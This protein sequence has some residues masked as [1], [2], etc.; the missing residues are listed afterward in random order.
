MD[1][2]HTDHGE[3]L[4]CYKVGASLGAGGIAPYANN[5]L[6]YSKNF[7]T[8]KIITTGPLRTIFE[9]SYKP[10]DFNGA[11]ISEKKRITLDAGSNL[12]KV[13]ITYFCINLDTIPVAIGITKREGKGS[14]MMNEKNG[15]ISYWEPEQKKNGTTGVGIIV[16]NTESMTVVENHLTALASSR[17]SR[18]FQYY[19]GAAWD[20]AG[21]IKN[22]NQWTKYLTEYLLKKQNPVI[23]KFN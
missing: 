11:E 8:Y 6:Y 16:P 7:D 20:K 13:E 9:L 3:G 22:Y 18:V 4:D 23:V 15:I 17:S 1:K 12:N 14:I 5:K 2:Y 19:Q 10:W 21:I